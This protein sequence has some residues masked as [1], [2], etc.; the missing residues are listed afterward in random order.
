MEKRADSWTRL[1]LQGRTGWGGG[2]LM[3]QRG[4][5]PQWENCTGS[6]GAPVVRAGGASTGVKGPLSTPQSRPASRRCT[7]ERQGRREPE[8]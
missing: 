7:P 1:D 3:G 5:S 2:I 6:L 8:S 4:C